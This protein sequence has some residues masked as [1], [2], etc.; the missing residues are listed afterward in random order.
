[1]AHSP[2]G[3][4]VAGYVSSSNK[5]GVHWLVRKGTRRPDGKLAWTTI[6]DLYA[7]DEEGSFIA[8][9]ESVA[10]DTGGKV[11]VVGKTWSGCDA[12][13]NWSWT[14]RRFDPRK[15]QFLTV[16]DFQ[17]APGLN[18]IAQEVTVTPNG[19]CVGGFAKFRAGEPPEWLVRHSPTGD[20]GTWI[21][22]DCFTKPKRTR[23]IWDGLFSEEE[24]EKAASFLTFQKGF[25][26]FN[27][28]EILA[29]GFISEGDK[30]RLLVRSLRVSNRPLR[31]ARATLSPGAKPAGR[32]PGIGRVE[33]K[34]ASGAR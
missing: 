19:V 20:P 31:L 6:D 16:D 28:G 3:W 2:S 23:G 17:I 21:T 4:Y 26:A 18:A 13:C 32:P 24:D 34:G 27:D 14:V 10:V 30:S 33:F 29:G 8:R 1:M 9:P 25:A 22:S 7:H 15:G 5:A 12:P 11:Y